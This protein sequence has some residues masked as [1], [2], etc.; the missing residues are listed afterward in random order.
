MRSPFV[1]CLTLACLSLVDEFR[2]RAQSTPA[3]APASLSAEDLIRMAA[4]IEREVE[5]IR[6]LK[7]KHPVKT[8]VRTEAELRNYI[9]KEVF[10]E[11]LGGGKLEQTQAFL[12]MLGLIPA[13]CDMKKTILDVL[14]NQI[15]GYYDPRTKAFYMLKR[16]GVGYGPLL[17]RTLIAHELTHALD[18]QHYDLARMMKAA[19]ASED[20]AL[21][22]GAVVEGSATQ[23]MTVYMAKAIESGK[24]GMDELSTVMAEEMKR[25]QPFLDAPRYFTTLAANYTLGM[26]FVLGNDP[27]G[28]AAIQTISPETMQ[29]HMAKMMEDPPQSS[30]QIIHPEKYWSK[31]ARDLPVVVDDDAMT[32][33]ILESLASSGNDKQSGAAE[34]SRTYV[35]HKN[36]AGEML[37]ALVSGK[38][39]DPADLLQMSVPSYWTNDAA[40]GWGGDRFYLLSDGPDPKTAETKLLNPRGAWLTIWDRPEDREEF[41]TDYESYTKSSSRRTARIGKRAALFTFGV[42][43]A[44]VERIKTALTTSLPAKQAGVPWRD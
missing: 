30:E 2:A 10:D 16:D 18:D 20:A 12:R 34:K 26:L 4:E 3:S 33:I 29:K 14:L 7:F 13:N 24:Y 44:D 19:E 38:N 22:L 9:E 21:S 8:N 43:A 35:V 32:K 25:S 28:V 39:E 27:A 36:T 41:V 15:G 11:Q 6:G 40:M 5:Q 17:N 37:C 23:L 42:D 1:L 31:T